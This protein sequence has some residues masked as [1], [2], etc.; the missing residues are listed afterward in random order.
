[1]KV[2]KL[3]QEIISLAEDKFGVSDHLN[4][5]ISISTNSMPGSL[6]SVNLQRPSQAQLDNGEIENIDSVRYNCDRVGFY[7][8]HDCLVGALVELE[9]KV[10]L[11]DTYDFQA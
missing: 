7:T 10:K 6:W 5:V 4:D 9:R 3:M 11:A 2:S 8:E 1:M